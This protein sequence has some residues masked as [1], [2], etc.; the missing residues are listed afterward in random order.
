MSVNCMTGSAYEN[1]LL[2]EEGLQELG[3]RGWEVF[4]FEKERIDLSDYKG[5]GKTPSDHDYKI[6]FYCKREK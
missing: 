4:Q 2:E 1:H 6:T 3:E 5:T